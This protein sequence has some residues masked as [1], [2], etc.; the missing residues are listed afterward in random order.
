MTGV[1]EAPA[2]HRVGRVIHRSVET[3]QTFGPSLW[4]ALLVAAGTALLSLLVPNRYT[5]TASFT[6]DAPSRTP[7]LSDLSGLTAQLGL[8]L[9]SSGASPYLFDDLAVSDTVLD[10]V[11]QLAIPAA[12]FVRTE[13]VQS[14]STHYNLHTSRPDELLLKTIEKLRK[15]V[16]VSVNTRSSVITLKVW[17]YDPGVAAW[18]A[19]SILN[20]MQQS[21]L[22]ARSSRARAE[23]EFLEG[24]TQAAQGALRAV[25]ETLTTFLTENRVTRQSPLLQMREAQLRRR[26]DLAQSLYA[27]L[28]QALERARSEEVRDTPAITVITASRPPLRKSAPSRLLL[29]VTATAAAILLYATRRQW[30]EALRAALNMLR[31]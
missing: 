12:V 27:T 1:S 31:Q 3:A 2:L 6:V 16:E 26:I 21:V 29:V 11:A 23:R 7:G 5:A 25:E 17:D 14:L 28:A 30:Q 4:F 22:V 9:S 18:L 8:T 24:R 20:Q 15:R 19:A 10:H 13:P